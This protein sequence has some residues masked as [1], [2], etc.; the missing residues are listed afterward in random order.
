MTQTEIIKPGAPGFFMPVDSGNEY[1]T[2]C[3][4]R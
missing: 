4:W 2:M 3:V 1:V